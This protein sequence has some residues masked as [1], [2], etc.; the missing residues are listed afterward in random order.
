MIPDW[1]VLD[2]MK[3]PK[4]DPLMEFQKEDI[5]QM[6]ARRHNLN[7]LDMG[8]GKT[9]E[10]IT[11]IEVLKIRNVLIVV[12]ASIKRG[13]KRKIDEWALTKR[14]IQI[15][16]KR[17]EHI[18]ELAE[19]III[20]YD[21]VIHSYI[22]AQL[23]QRQWDLIICDEAHYLKNKDA[24]RTKAI[25][26][27]G[28]LAHCSTRSLM[29]TGTP[30]LNRPI[31]LYPMLKTFAPLVLGKYNDYWKYA[32]RYCDAWQDGFTFNVTGASN[33]KELNEK[34]RQFYMIRRMTHEVEIQLPKK[35]YE[36]VFIDSTEGVKQ[37]LRVLDQASRKD[38][39]H[40]DLDLDGGNLS[41]LRRETAEAKID[42]TI[43]IIV[44][45][46]Q[47]VEKLVIFAYHHSVI[48]RLKSALAEFNPV[49]LSG[50]TPQ[51]SR[52]RSITT[53]KEDKF[54]KVFIGQI[55]AAGEGIDGLQDVCSNVLFLEWSW[56]PGEI[57][58]ACKRVHR[59]GQT[60]P[61]LIKFFVFADTVEE[62]QMRVALDKVQVIKEILK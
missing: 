48:D 11:L 34:L 61:V 50:N 38:F 41:V 28:G 16:D 43:D 62:H 4:G 12:K 37:K 10:A 39:K 31:E 23:T 55:Q 26:A 42:A 52:E 13:W 18:E 15:V 14:V 20:N 58:Q 5:R 17:T 44:E 1:S 24:K 19:I 49:I 47:S 29:L 6:V 36:M 9:I 7:A 40:Q 3:N 33:I 60:K 53:F 59:I 45:Y 22:F 51:L 32:K 56:V 2:R 57:E 25:L 30:V 27:K 21:L 35:R 8:L 46:A 54:C